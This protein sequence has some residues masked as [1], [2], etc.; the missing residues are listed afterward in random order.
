M[1]QPMVR[2]GAR[3]GLEC[4]QRREPRRVKLENEQRKALRQA[5]PEHG[6]Q[7]GPESERQAG[8][9]PARP[10]SERQEVPQPVRPESEQQQPQ[11]AKPESEQ[12]QPQPA[13]PE[14]EQ[15][16]PQPA[17]PE[18]EQQ[19]APWRVVLQ[20]KA[21]ARERSSEPCRARPPV[22]HRVEQTTERARL[23]ERRVKRRAVSRDVR[24]EPR[25]R[26]EPVPAGRARTRWSRLVPSPAGCS[27]GSAGPRQNH[28]HRGP[29]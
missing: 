20:R 1:E 13:K 26:S 23:L 21:P 17:K 11:Q 6:R 27:R 16:Q 24:M 8:P 28:P 10:E 5:G 25:A 2:S 7:A 14:S 9:Q 19:K 18:S 12:Q 22:D 15:Q 29:A 4:E 3:R